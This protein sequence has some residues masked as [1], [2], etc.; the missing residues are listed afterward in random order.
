LLQAQPGAC[1]DSDLLGDQVH[2]SHGLGYRM[3]HLDTRVHLEKIKRVTLPIDQK[4]HGTGTAIRQ[5]LGKSDSSG[6]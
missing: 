4:F 5:T 6:M 1:S 2:P 3:L